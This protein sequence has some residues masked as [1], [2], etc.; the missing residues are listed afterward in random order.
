M[1][2]EKEVL[3][4]KGKDTLILTPKKCT[5]KKPIVIHDYV[6]CSKKCGCCGG[7]L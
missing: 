5:C 3:V 6:N 2:D 7:E 1:K 4:I